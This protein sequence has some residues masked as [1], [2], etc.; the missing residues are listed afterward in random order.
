MIFTADGIVHSSIHSDVRYGAYDKLSSLALTYLCR[1]LA[2]VIKVSV[3]VILEL[4]D[5]IPRVNLIPLVQRDA[6]PSSMVLRCQRIGR[7]FSGLIMILGILI[8][9]MQWQRRLYHS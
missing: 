7:I 8:G 5:I 2:L 6:P 9:K 3:L 1:I 4:M